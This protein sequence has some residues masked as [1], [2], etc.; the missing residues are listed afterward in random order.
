MQEEC[1]VARLAINLN[2]WELNNK[3]HSCTD[4]NCVNPGAEGLYTHRQSGTTVHIFA[5]LPQ[6]RITVFISK[7]VQLHGVLSFKNKHMSGNLW[8]GESV[9]I[10]SSS[11][12]E[13]S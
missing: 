9:V 4:D 2:Y 8:L 1:A 10:S 13:R 7:L 5:I 6:F 12:N 11:E 3:Q